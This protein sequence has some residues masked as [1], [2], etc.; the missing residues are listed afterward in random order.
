[1]VSAV[2]DVYGFGDAR[3]LGGAR[4]SSPFV[5]L[6]PTRRGDGYWLVDAAGHVYA[7]GAAPYAGGLPPNSLAPFEQV[8]SISGTPSGQG[9]WI[10]T[11]R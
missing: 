4:S 1:M 5:D 9:Y 3:Y 11:T 10:F 2:G 6:E 7:F 8:T